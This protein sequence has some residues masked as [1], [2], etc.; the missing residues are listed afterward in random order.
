MAGL[1]K[2][3]TEMIGGEV[4]IFDI[5]NCILTTETQLGRSQWSA[6]LEE[7]YKMLGKDDEEAQRLA[8]VRFNKVQRL[9]KVSL[10]DKKLNLPEQLSLFKKSGGYVI[11]LTARN[12]DIANITHRQL[13]ELGIYLS[14][15]LSDITLPLSDR[16][17]VIKHNIIFCDNLCKGLCLSKAINQFKIPL[18]EFK[19]GLFID[20]KEH[21][22]LSVLNF[23]KTL[24][25]P[26][27][28]I[29]YNY[30]K[31]NHPFGEREKI[32]SLIQDK[33]LDEYNE[34]LT[35]AQAESKMKEYADNRTLGMLIKEP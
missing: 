32:I 28:V 34:F 35:D 16:S 9:A 6:W 1:K 15:L 30:A 7:Q 5:D 31:V 19:D 26:W 11:A 4:L 17:L 2:I 3:M 20:D 21:N 33:H 14:D 27:K 24:N 22:C 10:V 29:Q 25:L 12:S 8:N 23:F 13:I 18:N